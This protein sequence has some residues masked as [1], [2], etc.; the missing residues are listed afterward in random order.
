MPQTGNRRNKMFDN[1]VG[2]HIKVVFKEGDLIS[3]EYGE[4]I[5]YSDGFIRLDTGV[6]IKQDTILKLKP[7]RRK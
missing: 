5:E 6:M 7:A 4:L 2:K 1:L 3:V